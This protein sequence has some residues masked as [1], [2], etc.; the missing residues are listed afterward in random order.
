MTWARSSENTFKS[1]GK[2]TER[3]SMN[4]LVRYGAAKGEWKFCKIAGKRCLKPKERPSAFPRIT[5]RI[6]ESQLVITVFSYK[7]IL[8]N[9]A[10]CTRHQQT[11]VSLFRIACSLVFWFLMASSCFGVYCGSLI[12]PS[13]RFFSS[14]SRRN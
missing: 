13:L 8:D 6:M 3:R 10:F 12:F 5:A 14:N 1:L 9:S 11:S 4:S 2:T 7:K